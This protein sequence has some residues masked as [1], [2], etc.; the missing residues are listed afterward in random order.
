LLGQ[1]EKLGKEETAGME[2]LLKE[3]QDAK[4]KGKVGESLE[5][6]LKG[7][8]SADVNKRAENINSAV[9]AAGL[10]IAVGDSPSILQN[11][12]R[13]VKTGNASY[14][15][16]IEKLDAA[17]D[18][19]A[20]LFASIN[21]ARLAEEKGDW[22]ELYAAKEGIK[23][24]EFAYRKY[25]IDALVKI[26]GENRKVAADM[27]NT[28]QT[29]ERALQQAHIT[30]KYDLQK[31]GIMASA[32]GTKTNPYNIAEDNASKEY[33]DWLSTPEG[34]LAALKP[35]MLDTKKR[36]IYSG[37]YQRMQLPDPFGKSAGGKDLFK[38]PKEQAAYEAFA[39]G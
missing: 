26:T 11:I 23:K 21:D 1:Y 12:A 15:A 16:G 2:A 28:A 27:F 32:Y 6:Y 3:K 5:K 36:E 8:E 25:G 30:G 38:D 29:N 13:G 4:P 31:A 18:E 10:E 39:G 7:K 9:T 34:K 20:K 19:R 14:R 33:K 37:A 35:G 22:K 17:A 24:H